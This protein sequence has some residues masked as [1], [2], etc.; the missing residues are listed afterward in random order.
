VKRS[1]LMWPM[2]STSALTLAGATGRRGSTVIRAPRASRRVVEAAQEIGGCSRS[3]DAHVESGSS[4]LPGMRR[5]LGRA[6]NERVGVAGASR[7]RRHWCFR[8]IPRALVICANEPG[9]EMSR[10]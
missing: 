1:R 5:C 7:E 8:R 2:G 4:E 9:R 3:G 6:E 10:S